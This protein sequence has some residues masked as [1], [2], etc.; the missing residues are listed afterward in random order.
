ME[1]P[2]TNLPTIL[3]D[4]L[5]AKNLNVEKLSELTGISERFIN[6]LI[7]E[8]FNLLPSAPYVRGYLMKISETLN[9]DGEKIWQEFLKDNEAVRR[10][11]QRDELPRN[12]F[13]I[14]G[15]N[16]KTLLIIIVGAVIIIIYLLL[17][18]PEL[19]SGSQLTL[20]N[21]NENTVVHEP[22]FSILGKMNPEDELTINGE[23]IYPQ[24]DGSFEK[25]ITLEPNVNTVTFKVKRFLGK[26]YVITKQIIYQ[27]STLQIQ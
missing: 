26:E 19:L 12:R 8:K 18:I 11:G 17:R 13:A 7:E 20:L 15:L 9:L 5:R 1:Q 10:S 16:K 21:I 3:I 2:V 14:K 24:K 25:T 22:N 27:T 4:A 6:L 23:V